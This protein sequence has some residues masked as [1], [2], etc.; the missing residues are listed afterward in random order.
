MNAYVKMI[1]FVSVLG[2]FTSGLLMSVNI[3]T[4]ARII[5]NQEAAIKTAILDSNDVSFTAG[6]VNERFDEE[7]EIF[8]YEDLILY[9]HIETGRVSIQFSG[10]G[11]WGPIIGILTLEDDF[12]TIKAIKILQQEETP[13]LG[14]VVAEPQYLA[15]F[16]GK[17]MNP[18]LIISKD[19]DMS[20]EN[21]VDSITGATRT[22]NAFE[23][24]LNSAY[25][26]HLDAWNSY[27]E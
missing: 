13:G 5:A 18:E 26:E 16:V 15:K 11:V 19:A 24:I 17:V 3:L 14:G 25:S 12:E 9:I 21:E 27:N 23:D 2:L 7:I 4:E 22:S 1:I 10:E 6:N 20:N 8:E